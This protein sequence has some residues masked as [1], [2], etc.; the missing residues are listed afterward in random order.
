MPTATKSSRSRSTTCGCSART[1]SQT[2]ATPRRATKTHRTKSPGPNLVPENR[3]ARLLRHQLPP[4][5]LL[6]RL[7]LA[8]LIAGLCSL[9]CAGKENQVLRFDFL[10]RRQIGCD[11]VRRNSAISARLLLNVAIDTAENRRLV[12]H[13]PEPRR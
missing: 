5:I 12:L 2:P 7:P 6:P 3:Q 10:P 4:R 9:G 1:K 11:L 8:R 13:D